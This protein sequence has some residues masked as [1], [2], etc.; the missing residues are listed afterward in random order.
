MLRLC[1]IFKILGVHL[2]AVRVIMLHIVGFCAT[3]TFYN[4]LVIRDYHTKVRALP[5]PVLLSFRDKKIVQH[6]GFRA[7]DF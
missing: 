1:C 2:Q 5:E 3:A 6:F 4:H 7:R